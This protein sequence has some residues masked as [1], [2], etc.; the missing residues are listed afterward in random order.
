MVDATDIYCT[1]KGRGALYKTTAEK[2]SNTE[3]AYFATSSIA[4]VPE[5]EQVQN[6]P[7]KMQDI[8]LTCDTCRIIQ[9]ISL[10]AIISLKTK[11][12]V[13]Y[14]LTDNV[15]WKTFQEND[16]VYN[17]GESVENYTDF[18]LIKQLRN[19]AI[20][21]TSGGGVYELRN[22][23]LSLEKN[24]D[25][26]IY[27]SSADLQKTLGLFLE[28]YG[29][30]EQVAMNSITVTGQNKV[31]S[32]CGENEGVLKNLNVRSTSS[33]SPSSVTGTEN[34]GGVFGAQ[35]DSITGD[36]NR[37]NISNLLIMQR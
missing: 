24:N 1:I 30:I 23:T 26:G 14:L 36:N 28:N 3:S 12:K 34:V 27:G 31:G 13:T 11:D 29:T 35:S 32:F 33:E 37:L 9:M 6:I 19:N 25:N 4:V 5:V 22:L 18:I 15:D 20:L 17:L 21:R 7:L 8:S 10:Q 16:G 2:T